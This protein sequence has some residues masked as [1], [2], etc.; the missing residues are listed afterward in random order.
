MPA[1]PIPKVVLDT[2]VLFEGLTRQ[3]GASGLVID[4]WVAGL[5]SVHVSNALAYEYAEV[6]SRKLSAKRWQRIRPVLGALL[7]R[8]QFV[9]VYFTWRPIS[10]DQGDEHVIDC[11][12]NAGAAVVTSNVRHFQKAQQSL[13]LE[14]I[15][16][17]D[18][19]AKL[20]NV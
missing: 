12:M 1:T 2:N 11:A 5:L 4:A 18:L 13:G 10:P 14:V 16:P 9:T 7:T 6:L 3:G 20:A 15:T 8:A 17:L 19:A